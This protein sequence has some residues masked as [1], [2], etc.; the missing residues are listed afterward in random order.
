[1]NWRQ[2]IDHFFLVRTEIDRIDALAV[3][4][5]YF[6]DTRHLEPV[7]SHTWQFNAYWRWNQLG[8]PGQQPALVI[9][10]PPPTTELQAISADRQN[11]HTRVV[12]EQTNKGLE[13]LL[14]EQK[15]NNRKNMRAPDWFASKWL[16][17]A[18]GSWQ[19]VVTVVNDMQRWYNT[20]TCRTNRDWLYRRAL[21]G[22][23]HTLTNIKSDELQK[24]L[25]KRAFEECS[26]SVNMCCDGHISRLCNVL[27]GF[28][29]SF[30]PPVPFGEI[31]QNKMAAIYALDIE[32]SEKIK[33]ATEFFNEFAVPEADRVAWLEAF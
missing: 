9:Q 2:V 33:Q 7:F 27:V 14:E 28:D 23:Y 18:Y 32:T 1:M 10:R 17:R 26:E 6:T 15:K 13:K 21:D 22:L 8:R 11:V 16:P 5:R 12:S 29:D 30:A 25:F 4:R 19:K 20:E 24:E 31:L 3:S